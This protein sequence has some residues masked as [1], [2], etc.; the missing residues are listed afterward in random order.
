[1]HFERIVNNLPGTWTSC[2]CYPQCVAPWIDS[3]TF[4]VNGFSTDSIMPNF[5]T[6]SIPAMATV[7]IVLYQVGY[8][9]MPDT[10][11]FTGTTLPAGIATTSRENISIF[12]NPFV[13][14]ITF[15]DLTSGNSVVSIRNSLGEVVYT[16]S[17]SSSSPSVHLEFLPHGAYYA[18]LRTESDERITIPVI[19][20]Q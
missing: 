7:T 2:F 10:I 12:P 6:D 3:A 11:T 19:K 17:I 13:N 16:Q 20:A 18:E 1:M 9:T 15:N 5:G 8:E 4:Y 14:V